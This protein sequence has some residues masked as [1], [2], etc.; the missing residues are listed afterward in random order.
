MEKTYE[1][2]KNP[3]LKRIDDIYLLNPKIEKCDILTDIIS[4]SYHTS[5]KYN[6][7]IYIFGETHNP[8]NKC[9]ED[10]KNSCDVYDFIMNN[11]TNIPK[12]IDVFVELP[13]MDKKIE[14]AEKQP[15]IVITS[16]LDKFNKNLRGCL[17]PIKNC[18]YP[19]IRFHNTDIRQADYDEK[20]PFILEIENQIIELIKLFMG[21]KY[22]DSDYEKLIDK[23]LTKITNISR[24]DKKEL[25]AI[26]THEQ[27][28]EY[29]M[30]LYN[31]YKLKK[32]V[33]HISNENVRNILI[34]HLINNIKNADL[35]YF[36]GDPMLKIFDYMPLYILPNEEQKQKFYKL[37]NFTIVPITAQF[38]DIYLM[39]R[40]FRKF[41]VV[42]NQNSNEPEN[43]IV[44]VGNLHAE[45]Y[46]KIL[47]E[48]EFKEKFL[49]KSKENEFCINIKNLQQP[50]FIES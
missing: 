10:K 27:L 31:R 15:H 50:L 38:M 48:L 21:I 9:S 39:A 28:L 44:F 20:T 1:L 13:V 33:D 46:R 42:E 32:Q 6:K 34:K 41:R 23:L 3:A 5:K 37:W 45:N 11:I 49:T 17:N 8:E 19:N 14:Y 4:L 18:Q 25:N 22:K 26:K 2:K 43:I 12:M 7:K 30:K 24:K 29:L 47:K 36:S 35:E 40:M 16:S